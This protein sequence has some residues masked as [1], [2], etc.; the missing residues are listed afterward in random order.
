MTLSR[1]ETNWDCVQVTETDRH[2]GRAGIMTAE[3]LVRVWD[4]HNAA[5]FAIKD[6]DI[7]LKTMVEEPYVTIL[8]NGAGG[9]GKEQV[10]DFYANVLIRQWPESSC[11]YRR[12]APRKPKG[13][14]RQLLPVARASNAAAR[15]AAIREIAPDGYSC[16]AAGRRPYR[17]RAP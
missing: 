7:A 9:R 11:H 16:H 2:R 13:R 14:T 15:S 6:A 12:L 5:E 4:E 3:D 10:R 8:A 1:E 17:S